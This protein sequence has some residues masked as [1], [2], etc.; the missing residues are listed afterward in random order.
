MGC[1]ASEGEIVGD[2]KHT[3]ECLRYAASTG[4]AFCIASCKDRRSY[5]VEDCENWLEISIVQGGHCFNC[6]NRNGYPW[7]SR[8]TDACENFV[9]KEE[10]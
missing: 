2:Y 8:P 7:R 3:D 10:E 9:L 1:A 5:E 4:K 6:V